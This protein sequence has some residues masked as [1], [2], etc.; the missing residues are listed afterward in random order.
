MREELVEHF[1]HATVRQRPFR[2]FLD[3]LF[4][5]LVGFLTRF[6]LNMNFYDYEERLKAYIKAGIA[7]QLFSPDLKAQILAPY[8]NM[9]NKVLELDQPQVSPEDSGL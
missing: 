2:Q 9:L 5:R 4:D 1:R 8:D 7:E 3:I 6:N